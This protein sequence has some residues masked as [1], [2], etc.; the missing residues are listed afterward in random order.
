M[1]KD[2]KGQER[3]KDLQ[4]KP[5]SAHQAEE[6]KGG[7]FGSIVKGIGKAIGGVVKGVS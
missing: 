6:V 3:V 7:F 4:E 2:E 1:A 5:L